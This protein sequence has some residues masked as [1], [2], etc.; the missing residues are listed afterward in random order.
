MRQAARGRTHG[1]DR[2]RTAGRR[3]HT[4]RREEAEPLHQRQKDTHQVRPGGTS[5]PPPR[6]QT[7]SSATVLWVSGMPVP[8]PTGQL[9]LLSTGIR[10]A[11]KRGDRDD[12]ARMMQNGAPTEV[13]VCG[14]GPKSKRTCVCGRGVLH[15]TADGSESDACA[16]PLRTF[17]LA[18]MEVIVPVQRHRNVRHADGCVSW[19][20]MRRWMRH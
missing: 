9:Q 13:S 14:A 3:A 5:S 15:A 17:G 2:R 20:H 16:L 1:G 4:P 6:Q 11:V 18:G 7:A 19:L 12:S 8:P 10:P